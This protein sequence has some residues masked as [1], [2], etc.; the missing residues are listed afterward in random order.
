MTSFDDTIARAQHVISQ[1]HGIRLAASPSPDLSLEGLSLDLPD[2]RRLARIETFAFAADEPTLLVGPSGVGKST[3]LRAVAGV[4]PYGSGTIA[5]PKAKI[6]LLP[7]RPY[8]P[9]GPLRDAIAYPKPTAEVSDEAIRA[10]LTK[11]GMAAFAD[12]LDDNDNW[13]MRLSGGEQQRLAIA[14]ALIAAPDWLFLDEAT[15]ALDERSETQVYR[16]IA[17]ALPKT[18]LVSIGHRSTLAAF[19]K[20]R[21]ALDAASRRSGEDRGGGNEAPRRDDPL[22]ASEPSAARRAAP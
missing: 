2:G 16:A 10:A 19:H 18:T 9:I 14:R 11:V 6:V 8:I 13:Q 21:I 15:S 3:L 4:W 20:R 17:Q 5:E 22:T 12:R 1:E 7:Q